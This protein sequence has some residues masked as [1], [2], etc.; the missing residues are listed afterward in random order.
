M[1]FVHKIRKTSP[2]EDN[3]IITI[4]RRNCIWPVS[5]RSCSKC[6]WYKNFIFYLRNGLSAAGLRVYRPTLAFHLRYV[7]VKQGSNGLELIGYGLE[8]IGMH[9]FS[10]ISRVLMLNLAMD[11]QVCGGDW[12]KKS[13]LERSLDKIVMADVAS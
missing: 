13:L 6:D 10:P 1:D 7:T 8:S 4:S 9:L 5:N 12:L 3:Y 2:L 11:E